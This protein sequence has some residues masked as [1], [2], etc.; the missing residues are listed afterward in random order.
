MARALRIEYPG[1]VYHVTVRMLG[2]A[3]SLLF[4]D[5]ADRE[6]YLKCLAER[7]ELFNVRIYMFVLMRNHVHMVLETPDANISVFM[8][9]LNTSYTLYYNLRHK[10]HGHLFD[11]RFKSKL[12]E[13]D[14]YLL[15]L[16]RY[17]HL[18]PVKIQD[19]WGKTMP[20]RRSYLR[21]YPW[22]SYPSYIGQKKSFEFIDDVPVLS[23]WKGTIESKRKTYRKYVES[24]LGTTDEK[25]VEMMEASP[26][27]IGN[28]VFQ[29]DIKLLY[30]EEKKRLNSEDVSYRR[31]S[32]GLTGA[33]VLSVIA[34]ILHERE[35][36]FFRRQRGKP[37][38]A[39]ACYFLIK[40]AGMSQREAGAYLQAGS[41]SATSKQLSRWK[42][43][44]TNDKELSKIMDKIEKELSKCKKSIMS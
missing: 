4:K 21:R 23:R 44:M 31:D 38:R 24:G 19:M 8:H 7:L 26:I 9:A 25:M 22:S 10:R 2:N 11:G 20:E 12:V 1:A 37:L 5:D 32:A 6:R 13:A 29:R 14:A 15:Q 42:N 41:G 33:E 28:V 34:R 3:E 17:V 39:V 27:S 30:E 40:Y 43:S 35:D 36:A 16:S 18:N